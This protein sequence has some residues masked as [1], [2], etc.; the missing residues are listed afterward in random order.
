MTTKDLRILNK[1]PEQRRTSLL[2]WGRRAAY[3]TGINER[4]LFQPYRAAYRMAQYER[5][6]RRT[7]PELYEPSPA[8]QPQPATN[9]PATGSADVPTSTA[10]TVRRGW[11]HTAEA[12][13]KISARMRG[14]AAPNKG[15]PWSPE[16]R[17]KIS[18]RQ[19]GRKFSAEH[20]AALCA[21]QRR[22]YAREKPADRAGRR[23]V[24]TGVAARA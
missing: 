21:A 24:E 7:A 17:A 22:R 13:A 10:S 8:P 3:Q 23:A 16:V 20:R 9:V 5:A 2:A 11:H 6:C 15:K 4:A 14:R 19:R 12:R 18:E 1:L